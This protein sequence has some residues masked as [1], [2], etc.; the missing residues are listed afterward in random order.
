MQVD[1]P[2]IRTIHR[3]LKQIADLD[4]RLEKGPRQI[5]IAQRA[6]KAFV[7]D[8]ETVK[9]S[10]IKSKMSADDKQLQLAEREARIED[11]KIKRNGVS[12][13]KEFQLLT[14]QIAADEQ[15]NSVLSDEILELLEKIDGLDADVV[16]AQENLE[17]SH[18]ETKKVEERINQ[19]MANLQ[20][21]SDRV[22]N[23]LKMH[24]SQ[25]P[26]E[27]KNEYQRVVGK[28]GEE[29]LAETDLQTCGRCFQMISPQTRSELVMQQFVLCKS[30]GSILYI[31][32]NTPLPG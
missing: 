10:R 27:L 9:D 2:L 5:V 23:E 22:A 12:S 1:Y 19:E 31:K 13:N 14:D 16:K 18:Q 8:M 28:R 20:S 29:T 17:K 26:A 21:E 3:L 11:L 6:E 7:A 30:C 32:E 4:E 25:L 15:A 24:E